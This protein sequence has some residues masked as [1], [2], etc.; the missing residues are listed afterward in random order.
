M[1]FK[2]VLVLFVFIFEY[3]DYIRGVT[4]VKLF[5]YFRDNY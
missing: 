2:V 5:Y 4:V 3:I 1:K